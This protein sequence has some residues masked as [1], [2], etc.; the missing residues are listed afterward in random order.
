MRHTVTD[1]Q[2][3]EP[4]SLPSLPDSIIVHVHSERDEMGFPRV[5]VTG[6]T[7]EAVL[8]YVLAVW[9]D[10]D[11]EWFDEYVVGRLHPVS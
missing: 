8:E 6:P 4:E 9:G 2:A 3:V 7:R 10:N 11:R 5:D 1:L